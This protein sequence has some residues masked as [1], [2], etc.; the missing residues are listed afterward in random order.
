MV[1]ELCLLHIQNQ[2]VFLVSNWKLITSISL[3]TSRAVFNVLEKILRK[4]LLFLHLTHAFS[5]IIFCFLILFIYFIIYL[6]AGSSLLCGLFSNCGKQGLLASCM[7]WA[8]L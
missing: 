8:S 3:I 4:H 2:L 1:C 6:C 7:A 5:R